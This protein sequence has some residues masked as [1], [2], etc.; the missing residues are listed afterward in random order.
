MRLTEVFSQREREEVSFR[1]NV[2]SRLSG[3]TPDQQLNVEKNLRLLWKVFVERDRDV[4]AY[5]PVEKGT[6]KNTVAEIFYRLNTTGVPLS[7]SD[8]LFSMI[9]EEHWDFEEK[10][11]EASREI[12]EL[13]QGFIFT[14]YQLLQFLYLLKYGDEKVNPDRVSREDLREFKTLWDEARVPVKSFFSDFLFGQFKIT[15]DVIVPRK[16]ALLPLLSYFYYAYQDTG[17]TFNHFSD[18]CQ[19]DL[20]E[21]FIRS[22]VND[23]NLA[24][25]VRRIHAIVRENRGDFPLEQVRSYIEE[26]KRR[27]YQPYES[28]F[29]QIPLFALKILNPNRPLVFTTDTRGNVRPQIDHIFPRNPEQPQSKAYDDVVGSLWN[30]QPVRAN[31]NKQK[32]NSMPKDF[33]QQ[34]PNLLDS[35]YDFIPTRDLNDPVWLPENIGDFV[36]KRRKMM[37]DFLAKQYGIALVDDMAQRSSS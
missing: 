36:Q 21:F 20:K 8:I 19:R 37:L 2:L 5:F 34:H 15:S 29:C 35:E 28:W 27:P 10:L 1:K 4:L 32:G 16:L 11:L 24:T 6:P 7:Q 9:K 23:W 26:E 14:A 13:T 18:K 25:I 12:K 31:I 30:L 17:K 33:F 22:Q 3:I